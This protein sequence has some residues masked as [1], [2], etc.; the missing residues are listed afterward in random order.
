[1]KTCIACGNQLPITEFYSHP[2]MADKHLNKCKL[3]CHKQEQE[4]RLNTPNYRQEYEQKRWQEN[5]ERRR[6]VKDYRQR[7]EAHHEDYNKPL[8]VIWVCHACHLRE[9]HLTRIAESTDALSILIW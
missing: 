1:M 3:C 6:L 2:K 7:L 5:E 8:D 9:F 4:R